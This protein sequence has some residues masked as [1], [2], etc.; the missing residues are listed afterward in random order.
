MNEPRAKDRQV[1]GEHYVKNELQPWDVMENWF[2]A[3]EF[4]GFLRG[5]VIKYVARY[6]DKDGVRDLSK[7]AHYLERLIELEGDQE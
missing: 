3:E 4:A 2:S 1:A 7:A 6:R 5:N